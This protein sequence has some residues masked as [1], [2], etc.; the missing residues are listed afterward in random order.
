MWFLG[1]P[2]W[3]VPSPSAPTWASAAPPCEPIDCSAHPPKPERVSRNETAT[4]CLPPFYTSG[5]EAT[6]G[7]SE[8]IPPDQKQV[9]GLQILPDIFTLRPLPAP[10]EESEKGQEE[11][12]PSRRLFQRDTWR[13]SGG[14]S[15][16]K[17]KLETMIAD[18]L[19]GRKRKLGPERGRD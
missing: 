5:A 6:P 4:V 1:K 3:R 13:N 9:S 2:G 12:P 10:D 17:G 15:A 19:L 8:V 7:H 11:A 16:V 18:P 14:L